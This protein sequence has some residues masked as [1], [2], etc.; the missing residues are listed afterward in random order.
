MSRE[1][2]SSSIVLISEI[3]VKMFWI[4]ISSCWL[5]YFWSSNNLSKSSSLWCRKDWLLL[6]IWTSC[7]AA[8]SLALSSIYY[9]MNKERHLKSS[10]S[11]SFFYS[12]I[13]IEISLLSLCYLGSIISSLIRL[14]SIIDFHQFFGKV[15]YESES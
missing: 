10:L 14:L 6:K 5:C 3:E 12:L 11:S 1:T 13:L 8:S 7:F 9:L 2:L 15:R 4:Q